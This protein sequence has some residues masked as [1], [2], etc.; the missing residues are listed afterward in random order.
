MKK[1]EGQEEHLGVPEEIP[2]HY[3]SNILNSINSNL[4]T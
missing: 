1:L 4:N 3:H 2:F